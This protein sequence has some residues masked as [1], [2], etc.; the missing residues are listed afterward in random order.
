MLRPRMRRGLLLMTD[1][2]RDWFAVELMR[3]VPD[4]SRE[5]HQKIADAMR[6]GHSFATI[7]EGTDIEDYPDTYAWL[8]QILGGE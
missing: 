8:K 2:T 3:G 5:A 7:C 4:E 6:E 1:E